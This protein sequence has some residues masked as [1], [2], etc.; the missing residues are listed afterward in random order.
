MAGGSLAKTP[1]PT[2]PE[3]K[4]HEKGRLDDNL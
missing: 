3:R 4:T 2:L 1:N